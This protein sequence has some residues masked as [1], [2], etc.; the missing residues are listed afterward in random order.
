MFSK[1]FRA[2][3][4]T[5][6]FVLPVA[7]QVSETGVIFLLV[8]PGARHNGMG[9]TGV[10]TAKDANAIYYNPGALGFIATAEHP[11]DIE[12]M[13]VNWLPQ[14]NLHDLFYDYGSMSWYLEDLGVVGYNFTYFNLGEQELTDPSGNAIG[15]ISSFEFSTG[16]SYATRLSEDWGVGGNLKFIYSRLSPKTNNTAESKKG[17]GSVVAIDLGFMKKNFFKQDLTFGASLSNIGP[18]ITYIDDKQA[19][20]LPTNARMGVSYPV[21]SDDYNKVVAAYEVNRLIARGRKKGSSDPL[22]STA[23]P[24]NGKFWN[25]SSIFTTWADNGWHRLGHNFGAEY[26]YSDFVALRTGSSLDFAGKVYDMNFGVGIKYDVFKID[27]AYT[28]G[29][30]KRFNPRDQSQFYS[31]GFI[32]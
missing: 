26:T 23:N 20:P 17:A 6:L 31:I 8:P 13:H 18:S 1:Y 27:F 2:L 24:F 5:I 10:S 12:F 9:Q 4:I 32:F 25:R 7:G 11:R 22:L 3:T 29:L 30:T 19:D 16:L 21:Y 28:V 14:F 15:T